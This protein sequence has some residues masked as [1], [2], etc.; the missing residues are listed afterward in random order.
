M[1]ATPAT[2]GAMKNKGAVDPESLTYDEWDALLIEEWFQAD[3]GAPV[4]ASS[5]QGELLYAHENMRAWDLVDVRELDGLSKV[6]AEAAMVAGKRH[7]THNQKTHGNKKGGGTAL[8]DRPR[9]KVRHI[10][11]AEARGDSRPVS[12]QEFE[13]IAAQGKGMLDQRYRNRAPTK[14]LDRNWEALKASSYAEV[15]K[16]WGGATINPH[17]GVA[18]ESDAD[19]YALSVKPAGMDSIS[20]PET[21]SR[22]QFDAAMDEAR[23]SFGPVLVNEGSHLGIFHDDEHNR[24]DIDPVVVVDSLD[25]VEAIGAYTHAIGGAYHF[26]SGDGFWPPHVDPDIGDERAADMSGD[27]LK[28]YWT[29]GP[30]LLKWKTKKH[31]WTALKNHLV[32]YVGAERAKRIAS[33]WFKE[34]FGYWPGSRKGKNPT[35]PG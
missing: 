16:S 12:A 23:E 10:T 21:A 30:G 24:I 20:I 22:E 31:P 5:R 19:R 13:E 25:E 34:V 15:Q 33:Q 26:K 6:D 14:G 7:G 1:T 4:P 11:K 2:T 29:K 9:L 28:H 18:L 17:T 8:L 3:P 35:G 32:K 27:Q